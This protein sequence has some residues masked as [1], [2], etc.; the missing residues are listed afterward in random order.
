MNPI[1]TILNTNDDANNEGEGKIDDNIN[2]LPDQDLVDEEDQTTTV[3][4]VHSYDWSVKDVYGDD[5]HVAI[6]C[7][8]LDRESR[9]HLLRF[10]DFPA[11]CHVELPIFVRNH[12]YQWRPA[13]VASFMSMLSERLGADAPTRYTFKHAK[14][15]YHY[16]G[17]RTFPML[18]LCFGNLRAMQHCAR[19]L[20]NPLKTDDW[21]FIKCNIWEDSVS[22]VRKLLTVRDVRYSQWFNVTAHRVEPELRISTLE[23]EYIAEWDTMT[24]IPLEECKSWNTKPGVLAFDIECYSN[25][26]RA[27][28]DKYNALHVAYMISCIYQRYRTPDTRRRY[29]IVIGDCNHIPA[30]KLA[31]CEIIK[32]NTEYEMI[33]AFARVVQ[34]TDPEILTGYNILGF[35]YPYLDHRVK[36][37]LKQWPSMGRIVGEASHMTSKT[38]KSGAYGHQS[39]NILQMEGRISIDLL[40]I[41]K[42]DYKLDKYDLNTVCRKFIGKTK[43]DITAPEMFLIYEDIRNTLAALVTIA[44]EAQANPNLINDPEYIARRKAAEEAFEAAK[45]ETTR[46]MEYCIQDSELVIEL[47]EKMNIWVGL[48]EMSN[49]VG[50]TIVELFTRGQQVRC[51]SQLYDLAARMGFVLDK[52]DTPGFK[53]AGGF[54]YEPIPGLYDNIICL[55]FASLYPSIMMAYNICYTTLVPPEL[56]DLVPDEDCHIIEFDQDEMEGIEDDEDDEEEILKE[57]N[58]K[59]KKFRTVKKHYRFK[60]YKKQEGLLPRLVRQLVMERRA[61]NRQIGQIKDEVKALERTEDAF[62]ALEGYLNGTIAVGDITTLAQRVKDLSESKPPAAPEVITAA[63]RDLGVAQ[64]F[65]ITGALK[66]LGDATDAKPPTHPAI[67]D[68][69]RLELE[70]A[71]LYVNQDREGLTAKLS[72]LRQSRE[73]RLTAI[74]ENKLL[75]VVLDKRQLALK[76]SANSFFGFLGVHTGGKMPLIEGAMSITAKGRELIGLVRRYIEERY[77]GVQIYGDTDSVMM[78]LPHIKTSKECNYWG[79]RLA[80]EI[81]GIKPGEKD[82]DDVVWPDGRAGLFPPPLAMEFEKA[83]RLLCLKKKKYAA[84]LIGKDGNFKTEDVTDRNGNVIGNRLMMLK[85]GIILARRDNCKFL[86][87]T[88]TRILDLIMSKGSLDQAINILVD[89]VQDLLDNRIPHEDLVIIRELGANY[90]SDSYFMKVFSDELKKA[91]K[92]VNPGDRLDFLIVEDPTATLLGH[93]MRLTEQYVERLNSAN[94]ERID[95]NYYIEKVLMNPINQLFEVGFKNEI[96]QLQHV[97]YRPTNRHKIIHL[98]RPVQ[99]ILKMRERGYDLKVFKEAVHYNVMK[100]NGMNPVFLNVANTATPA[101]PIPTATIPPVTPVTPVPRSLTLN[102][103]PQQAVPISTLPQ[104]PTH[105]RAP[106]TPT[107]IMPRMAL[108][109]SSTDIVKSPTSVTSPRQVPSLPIIRPLTLN[110]TKLP[111]TEIVRI[112]AVPIMAGPNYTLANL[113]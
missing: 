111:M 7:W 53:F 68:L 79:L 30:E 22:I 69:A 19:L 75:I 36:R 51:I 52:R 112:P 73:D 62:L 23:H 88:Y 28:P 43:H 6:H 18:Q 40:P 89:S 76:V 106:T 33:E 1:N 12:T 58:E 15:T 5:D 20:E 27:M 91:G 107:L 105:T 31:N 10:T 102:I 54:V 74:D 8:S 108:K 109:S 17:N 78:L 25:N 93:K 41:V 21:G 96:A 24:A 16:R 72:Q 94:P 83:M 65:N 104:T 99:I 2:N 35:D 42:R 70:I 80:Q 13:A 90:K 85:K 101:Q 60:F 61:V 34:E 100:L 56:E 67:L 98:D 64:L 47:M 110:I 3:L 71:Q 49:I 66:R 77:Q 84:L 82:C 39:I 14:K 113:S 87:D 103:I 26:H 55:D 59:A 44:R 9:P 46:V 38:W 37:W 50:T 32:V 86:R 45:I 95:Y 4:S 63:K 92:I 97:S 48:V 29:G 11:F 57:L 81:S